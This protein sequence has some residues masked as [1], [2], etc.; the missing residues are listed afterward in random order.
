MDSLRAVS[1]TEET[2]WIDLKS[3]RADL[4]TNRADLERSRD[5]KIRRLFEFREEK[6][7]SLF[8]VRCL[9]KLVFSGAEWD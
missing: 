8:L 7:F 9:R 6:L 4:R 2:N 3:K 1:R 5:S